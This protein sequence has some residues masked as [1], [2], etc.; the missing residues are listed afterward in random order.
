MLVPL[1]PLSKYGFVERAT[2][3]QPREKPWRLTSVA[4]RVPLEQRG[5]RQT[6]DTVRAFVDSI[7][8]RQLERYRIWT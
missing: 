3:G 6:Q 4:F 8:T 2:S 5:G 1:P 7:L